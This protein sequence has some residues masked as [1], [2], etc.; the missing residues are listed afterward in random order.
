MVIGDLVYELVQIP[1]PSGFESRVA[2]RLKELLKDHVD[3]MYTD[4][5]GNL[6]AKKN[7]TEGKHS[8]ALVALIGS[9]LPARLGEAAPRW[10]SGRER[11]LALAKDVTMGAVVVTGLA[12]AA[13]GVGFAGQAPLGAV[14]MDSGRWKVWT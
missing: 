5:M 11:R 13:G 2:N 12:S 8:L 14:P 1:G 4:K 10:L 3:E 9:W 7:G 6:I